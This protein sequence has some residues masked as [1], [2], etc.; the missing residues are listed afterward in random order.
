VINTTAL[1]GLLDPRTNVAVALIRRTTSGAAWVRYLGH[2]ASVPYET[3][4]SSKIFA[5]ANA[6]GVLREACG[7]G[8]DGTTEGEH[9]ATPFGDLL[10]VICSYDTTAKYTSNSLARYFL[11]LGGRPRIHNLV[12]EWLG[13]SNDSLGGNY[14][15]PVPSDPR[16]G[17][18][19][20]D[21][22]KRWCS[23][24][25]NRTDDGDYSNSLSA[26]GAAEFLRRIVMHRESPKELQV[27]SSP[28]TPFVSQGCHT[29][30]PCTHENIPLKAQARSPHDALSSPHPRR[31]FASSQLLS[32][33]AQLS[34]SAPACFVVWLILVHRSLELRGQMSRRCCTVPTTP[35]CSLQISS[36]GAECPPTRPSSFNAAWA[37]RG[38]RSLRDSGASSPSLELGA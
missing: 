16:Y 17:E 10:T 25:P 24:G 6:A 26:I 12:R 30:A 2:N 11:D 36:A 13:R 38:L 33:L 37:T 32:S 28:H 23:V 21:A 20:P 15:E 1:A 8:L 5:A 9:G 7:S 29:V 22:N 27:V 4:S 34:S 31:C 18:E 35:C 19:M 3:W 14:G